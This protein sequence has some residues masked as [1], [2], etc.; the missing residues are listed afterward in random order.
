MSE[1]RSLIGRSGHGSVRESAA[2]RRALCESRFQ[3][4]E[5]PDGIHEECGVFGIRAPKDTD[6]AHITYCALT[7]LQHRGQES[8]GI[9]VNRERTI[10]CHKDLGLVHEV[11]SRQMLDELDEYNRPDKICGGAEAGEAGSAVSGGEAYATM[12]VGHVRYSTSGSVTR[13]NAQPMVVRHVKGQLAICHNGNL[14]NSFA[15]RRSLELQGCI[16]HSTSDTEVISYLIT[17]KRL[18]CTASGRCASAPWRTAVSFLLQN[19]ARLTPSGQN[20]CGI[21]FPGKSS[22]RIKTASGQTGATAALLC[23]QRQYRQ[24]RR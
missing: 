14:V 3:E 5:E 12:A 17:R 16:F 23:W 2:A 15:L 4:G 6:V 7:S 18:N 22:L 10:V 20:S 8:A 11:F 9:A 24:G 1:D 19:P 21:F 13:E